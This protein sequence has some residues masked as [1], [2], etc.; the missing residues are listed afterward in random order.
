MGA[1]IGCQSRAALIADVCEV[2]ASVI[3]RE[4]KNW[5]ADIIVIGAHGCSGVSG[6]ILGSV[7]DEVLRSSPIPVLLVK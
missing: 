5:N 7:A 3:A 1:Q 2:V 6:L 4:A